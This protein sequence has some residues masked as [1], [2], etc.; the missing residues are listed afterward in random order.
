MHPVNSLIMSN[1]YP[2]ITCCLLT[3]NNERYVNEAVN[4]VLNQTYSPLEIIISDDNSKDRSFE[5]VEEIIKNYKGPH[6]VI[7]NKNT[8]N[9]GLCAHLNKVISMASGYY[10]IG[11]AGDDVSVKDRVQKVYD[12]I[13]NT[14][15]KYLNTAFYVLNADKATDNSIHTKNSNNTSDIIG[16]L[17]N[18]DVLGAT[19][20]FSKDLFHVFGNLGAD[21]FIEDNVLAFR[22]FL[23]KSVSYLNEPTVYYRVHSAN[24][25]SSQSHQDNTYLKKR[26]DK[27]Y[28]AKEKM[29]GQFL[30]DLKTARDKQLVT[31]AEFIQMERI[32]YGLIDQNA[33]SYQ[34]DLYWL[35]SLEQANIL[36]L[37]YNAVK[38]GLSLK[39]IAWRILKRI[40]A[41]IY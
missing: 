3:Y 38:A 7:L 13:A 16:Y 36:S 23:L 14:N 21:N 11:C 10:I 1:E 35:K 4:S 15:I 30:R 12:H 39:F 27:W 32:I 19:V 31:S 18:P 25:S 41:G 40:R 33:L 8:V 20:A 28:P 2:L 22:G 17:K 24:L 26:F 6:K 9:M 37:S 5:L 34:L 29:Y